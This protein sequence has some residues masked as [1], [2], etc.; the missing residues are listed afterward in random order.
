[1]TGFAITLAGGAGVFGAFLIIY[2]A[3]VIHG[4]YTKSGSGITQRPYNNV[5]GGQPGARGSSVLSHDESAAKRYT[6]G[7]R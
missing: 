3:A 5:Y 2:F 7:T 4:L 1:M 6:R